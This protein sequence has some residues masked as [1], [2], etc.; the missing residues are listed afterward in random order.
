MT[1]AAK[2]A[3]KKANRAKKQARVAKITE[4]AE[5]VFRDEKPVITESEHA[6][7]LVAL[8]ATKRFKKKLVKD[9]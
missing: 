5:A 8:A 1:T 6:R 4:A 7:A 2:R 9:A 3:S